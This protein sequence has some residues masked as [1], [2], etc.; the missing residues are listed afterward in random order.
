MREIQSQPQMQLEANAA[1][2]KNIAELRSRLLD[3]QTQSTE[4]E[5]TSAKAVNMMDDMAENIMV[6]IQVGD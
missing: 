5:G 3:L 1:T 6:D 2:D 4:A